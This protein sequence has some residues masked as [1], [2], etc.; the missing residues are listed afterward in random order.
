MR[1]G[2]AV[3]V[4]GVGQVGRRVVVR[5][6]R[7]RVAPA[8]AAVGLVG[9]AGEVAAAG[10]LV[11]VGRLELDRL[12]AVPRQHRLDRVALPDGGQHRV[13][14]VAGLVALGLGDLLHVHAHRVQRVPQRR[15]E[16]LGPRVVAAVRVRHLRERASDVLA[17]GRVDADRDLAEPVEVVPDVQ[18][19]HGDAAPGELVGDEV[20]GE[21]LAQ[22]AEVD[23]ARR[24]GAGGDGHDGGALAGMADRVVGRPGHPVGRLAVPCLATWSNA[25]ERSGGHDQRVR[26]RLDPPGAVPLRAVDLAVGAAPELLAGHGDGGAAQVDTS[27]RSGCRP[28]ISAAA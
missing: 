12:G 28:T 22:V 17:P 23:M 6:Q 2:V 14:V 18:V 15:L 5:R 26:R 16:V 9:E 24:A 13:P 8:V 4:A 27:S 3:E 10:G 7:D 19:P 20:H 11:L 21:E 25:T 1:A